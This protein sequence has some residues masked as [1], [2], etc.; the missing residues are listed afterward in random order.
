MWVKWHFYMCLA[1][2]Y[3]GMLITNWTSASLTTSDFVS[4]NFGFWVRVCISWLTTLVYVW[5]LLAP[6]VFPE[7][8][9]TVT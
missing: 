6:K 3:V 9:F 7:R 1:S 5:T 4:S 2:M 8:D